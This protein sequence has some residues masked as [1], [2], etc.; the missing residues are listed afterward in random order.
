M[1]SASCE[2]HD[3]NMISEYQGLVGAGQLSYDGHQVKVVEQLEAVRQQLH[4][5]QPRPPDGGIISKVIYAETRPILT[6]SSQ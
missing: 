5:Y 2:A 1:S 3:R 6:L 4:H